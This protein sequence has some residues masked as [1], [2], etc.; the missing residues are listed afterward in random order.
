M[1]LTDLRRLSKYMFILLAA[2]FFLFLMRTMHSRENT[3]TLKV[4][5]LRTPFS[6]DPLKYDALAHHIC[7][8]STYASLVSEYKLGEIQGILSDEWSSSPNLDSWKFHIRDDAKFSNGDPI[9]PKIIAQNLN[10]AA[11]L[12]KNSGSNSGL[13][14][15]LVGFKT[16][17]SVSQ[18]AK[19]ITYDESFVYLNFAKPMP[20]LLTKLSFGLYAIAHPSQ[21]DP[22]SGKW[23]NERTLISSGPY[24]M[25]SWNDQTLKLRLRS[26]FPRDN[27]L[28][29]PYREVEFS[30]SPDAISKAD[31]IIDFDDSLAA[32]SHYEFH[33]P[34]KSAIRYIEC[35]NWNKNGS[36]CSNKETRTQLRNA[37]Y[38]EYKKRHSLTLSFFPLA[39]KGI[40]EATAPPL[41][42]EEFLKGRG[43]VINQ[44]PP[45]PKS[46]EN[47][48]SLTHQQAFVDSF[49]RIAERT[50][51]N[52]EVFNPP[53]NDIFAGDVDV[54]FRMTA[55]LVDSP[56][57][58]I[59]FM[60]LSEQGIKIPDESGE[61][62]KY[63][64]NEN[65]DIVEFP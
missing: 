62:K 27:L 37:F 32:D 44:A 9:T 48:N 51:L 42:A 59:R 3:S 38:N 5:S 39:I 34:V 10:R 15:F 8:R 45:S 18:L 17:E 12:M 35:S 41:L 19:G 50:N 33:G 65:F 1:S 43:L 26:D 30:F 4:W 61:I 57:H 14:E 24:E 56:R 53:S 21:F 29:K 36:L 49:Q 31:I 25:T 16:I 23:R 13:L 60:F 47:L 63:V 54:R 11:F 58:D 64:K 6:T 2:A 40:Q 46:K 28:T 52:L 22:D 7:F 20:D 55:I